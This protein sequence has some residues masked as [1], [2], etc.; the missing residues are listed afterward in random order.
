MIS[1]LTLKRF[2]LSLALLGSCMLAVHVRGQDGEG[3]GPVD[4]VT[5]GAYD[6]L[7]PC[8]VQ[9]EDTGVRDFILTAFERHTVTESQIVIKK[10]NL[11]RARWDSL[12]T[13]ISAGPAGE[14]R[15]L[16]AC[17]EY[18]RGDAE[19][20]YWTGIVLWQMFR[21]NRWQIW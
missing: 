3:W 5:S 2:Q 9:N 4:T 12:E 15:K 7:N 8:L 11:A 14:E 16:P 17:M 13:I 1:R 18:P 20:L 10:F 21:Q 6:G 19:G